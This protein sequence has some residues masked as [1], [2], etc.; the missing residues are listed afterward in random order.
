M[1]NSSNPACIDDIWHLSTK[2][3][4]TCEIIDNGVGRQKSTEIK[5]RQKKTHDSFSVKSITNRFD[6]LKGLYG[7]DLGVEYED[8]ISDNEPSGT[9]VILKI[10]FKRRF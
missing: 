3:I 8:L 2:D 4:L 1:P 9:K 5:L 7:Q 6:I 10:P